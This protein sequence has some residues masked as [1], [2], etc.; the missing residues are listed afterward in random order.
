MLNIGVYTC[1]KNYIKIFINSKIIEMVQH[2]PIVNLPRSPLSPITSEVIGGIEYNHIYITY[3]HRFCEAKISHSLCMQ[4]NL[5]I[6]PTAASSSI[7]ITEIDLGSAL[8]AYN[9]VFI[10]IL[11]AI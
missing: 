4:R 10:A 11:H 1:I 6:S 7:E 2:A 3:N 8:F 5:V 9:N